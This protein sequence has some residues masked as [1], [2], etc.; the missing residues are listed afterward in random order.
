MDDSLISQMA[1]SLEEEIAICDKKTQV[2][3]ADSPSP[4][5]LIVAANRGGCLT[6]AHAFLMA[7]I[8]PIEHGRFESKPVHL[9]NDEMQIFSME[10]K[11]DRAFLWF[12][13]RETWPKPN[14]PI[15][16]VMREMPTKERVKLF[17][18]AIFALAMIVLMISGIVFWGMYFSGEIR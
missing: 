9:S 8:E 11:R 15:Q 12:Q 16:Y 3:T 6:L 14:G 4:A 13:R 5:W 18:C 10:N 1:K 2:T 7:A 17:G